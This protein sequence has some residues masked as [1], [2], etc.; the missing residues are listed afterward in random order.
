M[1]IANN[2]YHPSYVSFEYALMF[3]NIIPETVYAITSA[4]SKTSRE[5]IVNK[6]S[7]SYYRIKKEAFTGYAKKD[8]NGQIVLVAEPEKALAD[9]LYFVA[10]GRKSLNERLDLK[11]INKGKL[12]KYAKLFKRKNLLKLINQIYKL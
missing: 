8:F 5:F 4:T 10:I 12:I 9:Y 1:L 2:V 7:Y 11:E 6:L 3:Y